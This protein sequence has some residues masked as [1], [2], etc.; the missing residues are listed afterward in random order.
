MKNIKKYKNRIIIT[1]HIIFIIISF[2]ISITSLCLRDNARGADCDLKASPRLN[3]LLA[4]YAMIDI[5]FDT[6][7]ILMIIIVIMLT[8]YKKIKDPIKTIIELFYILLFLRI[9]AI[10]II[11][12]IITSISMFGNAYMCHIQ[13]P[14]IWNFLL[15]IQIFLWVTLIYHAYTVCHFVRYIRNTENK[16]REIREIN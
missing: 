4:G 13:V 9:V 10:N 6:I 5:I 7:L 15:S 2:G 1:I 3:V 12:S 14:P 16:F 8:C 11:W